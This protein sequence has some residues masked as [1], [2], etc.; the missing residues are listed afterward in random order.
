[1]TVGELAM[2]FR[3]ERELDLDLDVVRVEGWHREDLFDATGLRWVNPSPNMR[4]LAE[5]ILYPGMGLLET[6]NLSVGRGTDTPF[7]MV[8]APWIDGRQLA[9]SL[10]AA[11]LPGV[12]FRPVVFTPN[13]SKYRDQRCEGIGI[14]IRDRGSFRS[15]R[16]G[17]EIARQLRHSYP[18]AWNADA[19]L[20]LLANQAVHDAVLT[21]QTVDQL[22]PIYRPSLND[23][24]RRRAPFL[25]YANR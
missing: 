10:Q 5:A 21:G 16:T 23:F 18:D 14:S 12:Q 11:G 20:R 22:E 4:S 15:L 2:M 3:H 13:A 19:Y 7:E 1:M 8:G 9:E 17:F 25:L 6:T 24:L